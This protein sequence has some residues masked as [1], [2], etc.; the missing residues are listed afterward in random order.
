MTQGT[1]ELH[2]HRRAPKRWTLMRVLIIFMSAIGCGI[3]LY[4]SA[5]G[6]FSDRA[7][8]K[9]INSYVESVDSL[10]QGQSKELLAQARDYN[11]NLPDGPL[12]DP[13]A[14]N[15]KG[16][17]ISVGSGSQSY[18]ETLSTAPGSVMAQIRIPKIDVNLPIFHGTDESTLAKGVGHIFGSSLPVGGKGSH[19]VVTAHSGLIN[20]TLFSDLHKLENGDEFSVNVLGET[21]NYKVNQIQTVLPGVTDALRQVKG[22]DYLT[23]VTCTPTGINSHRLLIRGERIASASSAGTASDP[24]AAKT[25]GP[26]FPWWSLIFVGA[27]AGTIIV[28]GQRRNVK[29]SVS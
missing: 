22:K 4:P 17:T 28:T 2:R 20:A 24:V 15:E 18:Q 29:Q 8:A 13:Y 14:L 7:H 26:G 5:A 6:W 23:L 11:A 3:L 21:L 1:Q 10:G 9:E 27:V 16:E 25:A 12:R 19:S